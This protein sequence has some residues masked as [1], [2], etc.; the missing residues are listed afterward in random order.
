MHHDNE[1]SHTSGFTQIPAKNMKRETLKYSLYSTDF[2]LSD[3]HVFSSLNGDLGGK[4]F[5]MEEELKSAV[6][7]FL[8][9]QEAEWYYRGMQNWLKRHKTCL[10]FEGNYIEK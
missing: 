10:Y 2:I 4:H 1:S 7:A 8:Q 9:K 5:E 6:K 3:F